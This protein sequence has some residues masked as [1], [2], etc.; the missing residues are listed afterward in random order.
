V[1]YVYVNKRPNQPL[2]PLERE[3]DKLVLSKQGHEV[4]IKDGFVPMPAAMAAKA[5]VDLGIK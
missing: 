4:V 1:L 3:F 2:A 5:L